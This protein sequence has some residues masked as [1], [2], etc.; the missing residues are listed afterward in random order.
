MTTLATVSP[1]IIH[2]RRSVFFAGGEGEVER[3]GDGR[4]GAHCFPR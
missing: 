3:G 2:V 4:G 1:A